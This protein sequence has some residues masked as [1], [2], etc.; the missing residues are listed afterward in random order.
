M[1]STL[2]ESLAEGKWGKGNVKVVLLPTDP[3]GD[4]NKGSVVR[5]EEKS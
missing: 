4:D 5:D 1:T 2:C 3:Y